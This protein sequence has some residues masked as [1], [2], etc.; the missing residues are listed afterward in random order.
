MH[1]AYA[2]LPAWLRAVLRSVLPGFVRDPLREK[3]APHLQAEAEAQAR[4]QADAE[5]QAAAAAAAVAVTQEARPAPLPAAAL[6][7]D[8]ICLIGYLHASFGLGE[9]LR[10]TA[11]ACAAAGVPFEI[12]DLPVAGKALHHD[13]QLE[14]HAVPVATRAVQVCVY[15][16]NTLLEMGGAGS[17]A[18]APGA[19]RIGVWFW[20]LERF[21][22]A[23]WPAF[24][25]I[26]ELWAASPFI[27]AAL[28]AAGRKPV[29]TMPHAVDFALDRPY[30]RAQ[31]GLPA[32]VF[33]VLFTFDFESHAERK[34]PDAAIAAFLAAFPSGEEDAMLLIKTISGDLP[35]H[36]AQ[37]ERLR[38]AAAVDA[39]ISVSDAALPREEA[40]GLISVCD[41]YLSLHRSEGFGLGMA[42]AMLLGKPVVA[43]AYS[44]NLAFMN[45]DN[46]CLV[47]YA[48][49]PVGEG[50]YVHGAGQHWAQAD[51]AQAAQY[52]RRLHG[53]PA[54]R[55]ALGARAAQY[56][57]EHHAYAV[58]GRA[59]RARLEEIAALRTAAERGGLAGA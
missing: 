44:G 1:A 47:D 50:E 46:S 51:T 28:A 25:E 15:T 34:N 27:A 52:L 33:V 21:P 26:D 24:E 6:R 11:R 43:T 10:A 22:A 45:A 54:Y 32:D 55:A 17:R 57:R 29:L 35:Q 31:F 58:A 5:A 48:M 59:I 38:A 18:G 56:M 23:W 19:Y 8:G 49:V 42:E 4:A 37:F 53:E 20:E 13:A 30:G 2:L 7:G 36:Q 14:A 12:V 3:V 9:S 39:R 41:V 40:Y 16:A